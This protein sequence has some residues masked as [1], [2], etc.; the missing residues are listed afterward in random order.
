MDDCLV[1]T[2]PLVSLL[3]FPYDDDKCI[4]LPSSFVMLMRGELDNSVK[5][6]ISFRA[7]IFAILLS[8]V[9]TS[10]LLISLPP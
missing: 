2:L 5:V 7:W 1:I 3:N 8:S 4:E 9:P 6:F 10:W